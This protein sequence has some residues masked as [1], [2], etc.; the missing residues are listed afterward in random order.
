MGKVLKHGMKAPVMRACT[1]MERKKVLAS[2]SG[3]MDQ[4]MKEIGLI[5]GSMERVCICGK[6][7]GDTMESGRTM[8]WKALESTSGL[9]GESMRANTKTIRSRALASI[10]GQMEESTKVGGIKEN[11]MVWVLT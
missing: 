10:I 4:C 2:I 9:M 3:Q 6:T 8:T 5:T 7:A 11:S 1:L